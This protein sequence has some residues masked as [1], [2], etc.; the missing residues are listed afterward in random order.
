M[1]RRTQWVGGH[2]RTSKK[3]KLYYVR[4]HMRNDYGERLR[5]LPKDYKFGDGLWVVPLVMLFMI[6]FLLALAYS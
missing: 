1:M 5:I 3:G 4:G 2:Y 6:V